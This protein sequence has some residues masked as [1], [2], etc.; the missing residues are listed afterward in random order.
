M[1][2]FDIMIVQLSHQD[3]LI[4]SRK[5]DLYLSTSHGNV[6]KSPSFGYF[7]YI[8]TFQNISVIQISFCHKS[9]SDKNIIPFSMV[10]MS[11]SPTILALK[12][13]R[14]DRYRSLIV[15]STDCSNISRDI[16]TKDLD[17]KMLD[18]KFSKVGDTSQKFNDGNYHVIRWL[19]AIFHPFHD[20]LWE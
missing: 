1:F 20:S 14:W 17:K 15:E 9:C 11:T 4:L 5:I 10:V 7:C 3:G 8:S 2:R 19:S 18:E 12:T 16:R 6:W 13:S